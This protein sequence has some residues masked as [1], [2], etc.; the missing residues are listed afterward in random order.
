MLAFQIE[1]FV[2]QL[3]GVM[4][5][6]QF[7]AL[8]FIVSRIYIKL[9]Q[10]TQIREILLWADYID[11]YVFLIPCLIVTL[12]P[13]IIYQFGLTTILFLDAGYFVAQGTASFLR[14]TV[15]GF[16]IGGL[17]YVYLEEYRVY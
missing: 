4:L 15:L 9:Q 13:V 7:L 5:P 2:A 8:T 1:W 12:L 3:S 14:L 17:M 10:T 16:A 6:A 11:R